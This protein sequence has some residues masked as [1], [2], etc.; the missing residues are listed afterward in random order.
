MGGI[1]RF[2]DFWREF[3]KIPIIFFFV[4]FFVVAGMVINIFRSIKNLFPDGERMNG[5]EKTVKILKISILRFLFN[6]LTISTS[7]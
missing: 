4:F 7:P 1:F 2:L 3:E 6:P 5:N